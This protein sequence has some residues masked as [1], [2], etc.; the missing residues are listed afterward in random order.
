MQEGK[1]DVSAEKVNYEFSSLSAVAITPSAQV[2]PDIIVTKVCACMVL[3]CC[4]CGVCTHMLCTVLV[5]V[6][7][8]LLASGGT[9]TLAGAATG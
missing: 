8:Q 1:T 5:C 7:M 9:H 6:T 3:W 2:L 4:W